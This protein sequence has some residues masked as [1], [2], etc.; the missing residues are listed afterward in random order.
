MAESVNDA[1]LGRSKQGTSPREHLMHLIN[2]GWDPESPLIQKY[3]TQHGLRRDL[4][5]IIKQLRSP[6]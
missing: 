4:D 3:V 1:E 5:D 2:I 6:S